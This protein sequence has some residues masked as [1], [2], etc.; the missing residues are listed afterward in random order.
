MH[1]GDAPHLDDVGACAPDVRAAHIQKVGQ[2]HHMGL[3]GAVFQHGL[4]L[5]HDGGEH[6][7]HGGAHADLIKEDAGAL[8]LF[9]WRGR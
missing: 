8:Q 3:L 7:V 4:A 5:G 6:G 2:V 9:P 1:G